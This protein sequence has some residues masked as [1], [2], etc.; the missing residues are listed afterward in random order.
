MTGAMRRHRDWDTG[1]VT[2]PM[3]GR[4]E[5]GERGVLRAL[6]TLWERG[7]D[8]VLADLVDLDPPMPCSLPG[9][10]FAERDPER[11]PVEEPRPAATGSRGRSVVEELWCAALGVPSAAD[12]DDFFALG[13]ESL[14]AV[15]LMSRIRE[16]T[17]VAVSVTEFTLSPTFGAL[18]RLAGPAG[19][20]GERPV[21]GVVTLR[22]GGS[23]IPLI[24]AADAAGTA[25]SY[26]ELADRL[27]DDRPVY[28][29]EPLGIEGRRLGVEALAAHHVDA[30][31][32]VRPAGPYLLGGWSF[33][34]VLA[35]EMARQL[36]VDGERVAAVVCLDAYVPGRPGRPIALD[37]EY[38]LSNVQLHVGAALG[39]GAVGAQVRRNPAL[40]RLLVDKA[41]ALLPYRPRAVPCPA[42]VF[43][44]GVDRRA[45]DRLA[46]RLAA[47]YG[48][49]VEVHPVGGNHW[50]MLTPPHVGDLA[51]RLRDALTKAERSEDD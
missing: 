35:H 40:R 12:G 51:A 44:V 43:K 15:N 22:E 33:G 16:R 39:F 9:Y 19:V 36:T 50:S 4:P 42:L 46:V 32:R 26:R 5:D 34:T 45:A 28:G 23:G 31:R 37:P 13:G 8:P 7:A 17:G 30:V 49:G 27:G 11:A 47:F 24:L 6:G 14:M 20:A 38:L 41:R 1:H 10:P 18:V 3:L 21:V 29:L 2:V 25:L 48:G